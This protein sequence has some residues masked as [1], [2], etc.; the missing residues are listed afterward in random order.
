MRISDWVNP[1]SW[2]RNAVHFSNSKKAVKMYEGKKTWDQG[3]INRVMA[4][5]KQ[6]MDRGGASTTDKLL[7]HYHNNRLANENQSQR[8]PVVNPNN[9]APTHQ[10]QQMQA[11]ASRRRVQPQANR[12]PEK[13]VETS[14]HKAAK[15]G[16]EYAFRLALEKREVDINAKGLLGKTALH[17]AI[18]KGNMDMVKELLAKNADINIQDGVGNTPLH[19]AAACN[20]KEIVNLL[21]EK[22]VEIKQ[23]IC[24][25]SPLYFAAS[26]KNTEMLE[27]L[28]QHLEKAKDK[29]KPI[30]EDCRLFQCL[31]KNE[32][33]N[34]FATRLVKLGMRINEVRYSFEASKAFV[35]ALEKGD[36]AFAKELL[37][38]G[39]LTDPE[40]PYWP[41]IRFALRHNNPDIVEE[42]IKM[43]FDV[44]KNPD[45]YKEALNEAASLGYDGL[46]TMLLSAGVDRSEVQLNEVVKNGHTQVLKALLSV[47][48]I[49]REEYIKQ[50]DKKHGLLHHVQDVETLELLIS[51]GADP[52]KEDEKGSPPLVHA[53]FSKNIDLVKALISN[54]ADL[55][56]R[57]RSRQKT[58]LHFAVIAEDPDI[59]KILLEKGV[60]PKLTDHMGRTPLRIAGGE[61]RQGCAKVLKEW[62]NQ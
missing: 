31:V 5:V 62:E 59:V 60:D 16:K 36:T 18:E 13:L 9:T 23:N 47:G 50:Q 12:E 38:A 22:G 32:L 20:R 40:P 14:L 11:G 33:T 58:L 56:F 29:G 19:S 1:V 30:E 3:L 51:Y 52:N 10:Y 6:R 28:V 53:I 2:Y 37:R 42:L 25:C 49:N 7:V 48:D 55:N 8:A 15:E 54:G 35:E 24:G 44:E 41:A 46:V 21:L 27:N 57:G 4:V 39:Y 26:N 34:N 43:G 61:S 45:H 17:Y